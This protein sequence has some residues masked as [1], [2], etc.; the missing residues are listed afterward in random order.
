M[1]ADG[2]SYERTAIERWIQKEGEHAKSPLTGVKLSSHAVAT[3][4]TLRKTINEAV[5]AELA[6]QAPGGDWN[7]RK[8]IERV[9]DE[10]ARKAPGGAAASERLYTVASERDVHRRVTA[11]EPARK[12]AFERAE[13]EQAAEKELGANVEFF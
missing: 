2:H 10:L 8:A 5:D 3:N 13:A 11:G 1:A 4:W 12:P 9:G 6:R 7:L